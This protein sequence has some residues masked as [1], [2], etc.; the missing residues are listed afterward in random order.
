MKSSFFLRVYV[1]RVDYGFVEFL[2]VREMKAV[3][4]YDASTTGPIAVLS[5]QRGHAARF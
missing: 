1:F 5:V 3:G 4:A 2:R